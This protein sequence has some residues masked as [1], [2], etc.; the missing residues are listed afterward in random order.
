MTLLELRSHEQVPVPKISD[1]FTV[2]DLLDERVR[3]LAMSGDRA[4]SRAQ[5]DLSAAIAARGL[6][7]EG[8]PYPVSLRPFV[9]NPTEAQKVIT[10]AEWLVRVLDVA[11]R[12]YCE[13]AQVRELFPACESV[14]RYIR[15]LP[16]LRPLVRVCRLD[17]LIAAN[18]DYRVLE[19]NTDCPGGVIQN[20]LAGRV[21]LEEEN[22]LMDG[23][24]LTTEGQ[25]FVKDPDLFLR[26]L[27]AA[28]RERTGT[29][30]RRGLIVN[31]RGRYT[32]EVDWM[33]QG[34]KRLGLEAALA[35]AGQ[36][37]RIGNTLV[38][39]EGHPVDV[40]YNKY[41]LRDL[42][43]EPEVVDYLSAAAAGEV[44]FI[45]PL[46]AQWILSDKAIFAI[47]SDER[48]QDNYSPRDRARIHRHIPWTRLL[49]AGTTRSP[50]GERIDLPSFVA[51]NQNR[52]VLKPTNGTRGEG[53]LVGPQ[54]T[55]GQWDAG[56]AAA[57]GSTPYVVQEYVAPPPVWTIHPEMGAAEMAAGLDVYVF[58]GRFAGFQARASVDP[59]MNIGRRGILLPVAMVGRT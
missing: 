6:H 33:V 23:L 43:G 39:R 50:D 17:G 52:L 48:F 45:N 54:V 55:R 32:N 34:L 37:R 29:N 19:T 35:D 36:L 10:V 7:F 11:A 27:L 47:L 18:G 21:W 14:A 53:V 20:G 9:L 22:P 3:E 24:P 5:Q 46:I 15:A 49:A 38:D 26:E 25:P 2:N 44:T 28:H 57:A 30:A 59:V 40:T 1:D 12:L 41:E 56:L 58:G 13:D 51:A 42:I 8:R 4:V 16:S 31:Y